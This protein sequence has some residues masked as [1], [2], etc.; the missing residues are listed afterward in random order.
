M[1]QPTVVVIVGTNTGTL[2]HLD[3]YLRRLTVLLSAAIHRYPHGQA[4]QTDEINIFILQAYYRITNMETDFT[5]HRDQL[6]REFARKNPETNAA[7]Q[8]VPD[9]RCVTVRNSLLSP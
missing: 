2:Q 5:A 4:E 7:A 6:Y 8:R 1:L 9:Q 3:P